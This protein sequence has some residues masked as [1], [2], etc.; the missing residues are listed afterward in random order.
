[1]HLKKLYKVRYDEQSSTLKLAGEDPFGK[2][3]NVYINI[4]NAELFLNA[5]KLA[6]Q[7]YGENIELV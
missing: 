1:M 7:K 2:D 4:E 3:K 6:I 5:I